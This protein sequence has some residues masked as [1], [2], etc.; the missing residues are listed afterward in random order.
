MNEI[1]VSRKKRGTEEDLKAGDK[2]RR[3]VEQEKSNAKK[4]T[5]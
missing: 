2:Q 4:A 1:K 3:A 5:V